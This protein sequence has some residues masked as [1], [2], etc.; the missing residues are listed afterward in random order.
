MENRT[1]LAFFLYYSKKED[2]VWICTVTQ[3]YNRDFDDWSDADDPSMAYGFGYAYAD[4][5]RAPWGEGGLSR[6]PVQDEANY[7]YGEILQKMAYLASQGWT[8]LGY[9]GTTEKLG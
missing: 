6:K 5:N 2:F 1:R 7:V 9:R 8:F 4:T 3:K